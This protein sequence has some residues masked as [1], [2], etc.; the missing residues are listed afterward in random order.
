M[1]LCNYKDVNIEGM[2]IHDIQYVVTAIILLTAG[3]MAIKYVC[4]TLRNRDKGCEG[5]PL[6][7]SCEIDKDKKC[8]EETDIKKLKKK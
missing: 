7:K 6:R 8:C 1:Y 4:N 2:D 5:C 3:I